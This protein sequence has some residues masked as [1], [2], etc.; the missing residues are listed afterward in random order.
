MTTV[1]VK[2]VENL[3]QLVVTGD[4]AFVAD[5]PVGKGDGLGPAPYELMAWGLRPT[6]CCCRDSSRWAP[7]RP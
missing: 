5:E 3:Q 1:T 7:E 6:N 2:S 4:H